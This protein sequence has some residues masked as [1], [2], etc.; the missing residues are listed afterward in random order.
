MVEEGGPAQRGGPPSS[1]AQAGSGEQAGG[2][3]AACSRLGR[4]PRDEHQETNTKRRTPRDEHQETNTLYLCGSPRRQHCWPLLL[5]AIRT[6]RG[7]PDTA[8]LAALP[9]EGS[10]T[11]E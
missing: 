2:G 6:P 8:H 10:S 4:T 11:Y 5:L 3:A 9:N 1:K 7:G